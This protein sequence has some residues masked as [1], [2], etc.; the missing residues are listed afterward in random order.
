MKTSK[1]IELILKAR[2]EA[3]DELQAASQAVANKMST[4]LE[5]A[6]SGLG[7]KIADS[8][9]EGIV[10]RLKNDGQSKLA[11]LLGQQGGSTNTNTGPSSGGQAQVAG[12]VHSGGAVSGGSA[13]F[14]GASSNF[15]YLPRSA[16]A[17]DYLSAYFGM[18]NAAGPI[19]GHDPTMDRGFQVNQIRNAV[20]NDAVYNELQ[21]RVRENKANPSFG[22][23]DDE[24][25]KKMIDSRNYLN[26]SALSDSGEVRKLNQRIEELTKRLAE[27]QATDEEYINAQKELNQKV[28]QRDLLNDK[29]TSDFKR[30][31]EYNRY[32]REEEE[33]RQ[34]NLY[35]RI[36]RGARVAGA[37]GATATFVGRV[38]GDFRRMDADSADVSNM[39]TRT[40]A[41]GDYDRMMAMSRLGGV[42][43]MRSSGN[44]EAGARGVGTALAMAGGGTALGSMI[45]GASGGMIAG[46][47]GMLVGGGLGLAGGIYAGTMGF[48]GNVAGSMRDQMDKEISK[49]QELYDMLG[50]GRGVVNRS[51]DL[52]R[53][54]GGE[55]FSR[56]LTGG[57]NPNQFDA[58]ITG[59]D[60]M[61]VQMRALQNKIAQNAAIDPS[62]RIDAIRGWNNEIQSIYNSPG[63]QAAQNARANR[64]A[65]SGMMVGGGT[66]A[67]YGVNRGLSGEESRDTIARLAASMGGEFATGNAL[68]RSSG[69]IADM[70][71]LRA[72]GLSNVAEISGGLFQGSMGNRDEAMRATKEIFEDAVAGGLDKAATGKAMQQMAQESSRGIGFGDAATERFRSA[73]GAS[74]RMFGGKEIEGK[75]FEY[76]ANLRGRMDQFGSASG[77]LGQIGGTIAT[78]KLIEQMKSEIPGLGDFG[79]GDINRLQ[80]MGPNASRAGVE[81]FLKDKAGGKLVSPMLVDKFTSQIQR[82][83]ASGTQET[84]NLFGGAGSEMGKLLTDSTFSSNL[85]QSMM[86]PQAMKEILN[87]TRA[88][89]VAP[90]ERGRLAA[91]GDYYGGAPKN[92]MDQADLELTTRGVGEVNNTIGELK[93]ALENLIKRADNVLSEDFMRK[94]GMTGTQGTTG[95]SS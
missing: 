43:S 74:S 34:A 67:Q 69:S 7:A 14:Y 19:G 10:N 17:A 77:G 82:L 42:D 30:V 91:P 39:E 33:T 66:L 92:K 54:L 3:S 60:K 32:L 41:S 37:L 76:M 47:L 85:E 16:G 63:Y 88:A 2:L 18:K 31:G 22:V 20:T 83:G 48:K 50:R 24:F 23:L 52:S 62:G 56:L 1:E 65:F 84:Y 36:G 29:S 12:Q 38:P 70:M 49:N 44:F 80:S 64:E 58:A 5:G 81:A 35:R 21:L 26:E 68:S 40:L 53:S 9:M 94:M 25:K 71:N 45:A 6:F 59:G 46:P 73:L 28:S 93:S 13:P 15:N 95:G 78:N 4:A 90:G 75:G 55:G 87:G 79:I 86:F 51:I 57:V 61:D 89:D 27:L 72:R 11:Q 8:I